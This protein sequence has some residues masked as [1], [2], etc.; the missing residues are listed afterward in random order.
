VTNAVKLLIGIIT[1]LTVSV[2]A[3]AE[4]ATA[5]QQSGH[6]VKLT[7]ATYNIQG[8]RDPQLILRHLRRFNADII[9]LQEV[10]NRQTGLKLFARALGMN[11]LFAPRR[12][13]ERFGYAILAH[14][15]L[16]RGKT[17]TMPGERNYGFA[18]ELDI[19]HTNLHVICIHL[20][21]LPRPLIKGALTSMAIRARQARTVIKSAKDKP[22]PVI[23][24][25][26]CNA[27][28]FFP[29]Y[30]SL[31]KSMT[32]CCVATK[33]STQPTIFVGK[34]GYRIDH[35]FVKGSWN[36]TSCQ[37]RAVKGSDH[38]PVV[39]KLELDSTHTTSTRPNKPATN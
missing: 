26:D 34:V 36:V 24:A 30:L 39:A 9:C 12:K 1:G 38:R 35:I 3:L 11:Y 2:S 6:P 23:V 5:R 32:D 18:A 16:K 27:L 7:V 13:G 14:G 25:G 20:K 31:S 17:L 33:T 15:K 28:S 4:T 21:S 10:N 19:K 29:E 37:V 8:G 22:G